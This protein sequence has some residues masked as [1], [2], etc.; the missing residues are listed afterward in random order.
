MNWLDHIS[1]ILKQ[2]SLIIF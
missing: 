2:V 1:M